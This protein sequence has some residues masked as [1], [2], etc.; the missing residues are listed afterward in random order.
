MAFRS[1]KSR[2][3]IGQRNALADELASAFNEMAEHAM[4]VRIPETLHQE[5]P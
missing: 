5:K 3:A 1:E 4:N 2:T